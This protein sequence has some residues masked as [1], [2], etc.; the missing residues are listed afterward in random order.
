MDDEMHFRC[1]RMLAGKFLRRVQPHIDH[2]GTHSMPVDA[3]QRLAVMLKIWASGGSQQAVAASYKLAS[4][5]VS[6]ILSEVY[7]ALWNVLQTD[8]EGQGQEHFQLPSLNCQTGDL[9]YIWLNS[10][11]FL[12]GQY[13]SS[14]TK[15]W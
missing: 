13:N 6:R 4:S 15:L 1:F 10:E 9:K 2:K 8:F 5:T 11:E 12:A 3:A 14:K 7:K